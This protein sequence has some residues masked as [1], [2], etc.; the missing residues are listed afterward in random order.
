M[1]G[2]YVLTA[3]GDAALAM[4]EDRRVRFAASLT[5]GSGFA[6]F[7]GGPIGLHGR[8]LPELGFPIP[9]RDFPKRGVGTGLEYFAL[10]PDVFTGYLLEQDAVTG[11]VRVSDDLLLVESIGPIAAGAIWSEGVVE[12]RDKRLA[13]V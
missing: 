1:Q 5:D 11:L 2:G 12:F 6:A 7:D 13:L 3:T 9:W 10:V 4:F 8:I